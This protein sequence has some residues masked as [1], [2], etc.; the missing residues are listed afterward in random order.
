M[1]ILAILL[2]CAL[3]VTADDSEI[4][5]E[6]ATDYRL[7]NGTAP[8]HYDIKL[9][10]NGH[11]GNL[12]YRG[13]VKILVEVGE[14]TDQVILHAVNL[15]IRQCNLF[16][17]SGNDERVEL[18]GLNVQNILENEQ[19]MI[20]T[21]DLIEVGAHLLE[22]EF[23]ATVNSTYPEGIFLSSYEDEVGGKR[24]VLASQ[25]DP[26][27]ARRAY[28]CFDEPALKATFNLS[29]VH[30]KSHE[31]YS[32]MPA[33]G[34]EV[35]GGDYVET[36]FQQTPLMSIYLLVFCTTD[37]A[38]QT[39]GNQMAL[40]RKSMLE[41]ATESLQVSNEILDA[42]SK[43]TDLP[44]S[45]YVPKLTHLAVPFAE[46][47]HFS[48]MENWGMILYLEKFFVDP[49]SYYN[50]YGYGGNRLPAIEV[51]AHEIGHQWFGN[52]VTPQWWNHLWLK[53]GFA[54]LYQ[55]YIL[56]VIRP[57]ERWMDTFLVH[58][59]PRGLIDDEY[60]K[61]ISFECNNRENIKKQ[62][63]DYS[64]QKAAGAL[65][66]FRNVL[67][68]EKW[69]KA[70]QMYL[71]S[72]ALDNAT[73]ED[74]YSAIEAVSDESD[75]FPG[76]ISVE[77]IFNSWIL[78]EG[79][80]VLYVDRLEGGN[81]IILFQ[82][83]EQYC[84]TSGLENRMIPYNY[85]YESYPSFYETGPIE[86]L[87]DDLAQITTNA[88]YDEWIIFNKRRFGPYK[89]MYD[90]HNWRLIIRALQNNASCIHYLNRAQ[91]LDDAYDHNREGRLVVKIVF[92]LVTYLRNE[93]DLLVWSR[94]RRIVDFMRHHVRGKDNYKLF[95]IFQ[96][97]LI[98]RAY[99]SFEPQMKLFPFTESTH[100]WITNLACIGGI[101]RCLDA[102]RNAFSSAVQTNATVRP[103]EMHTVYCFG[104]R[105]A[106]EEEFSWLFLGVRI[107]PIDMA[108]WGRWYLYGLSSSTLG[109][110]GGDNEQSVITPLI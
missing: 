12:S 13:L 108:L 35:V 76:N 100:R 71:K 97:H 6:S 84:T 38:V 80:P 65:N 10:T 89:I 18:K 99:E 61:A 48:A 26:I 93:T 81:K 14:P 46:R 53:E 43:Y 19:L 11:E 2:A 91:L 4:A 60:T 50:L 41:K 59:M 51:I 77:E 101:D 85:A 66:M 102:A 47:A 87:T 17:L 36:V 69:Q 75:F 27:G 52:L 16:R 72:R 31:A 29:I 28:P 90:L 23:N 68:D 8:K 44:Y 74:L 86:W 15:S 40:V 21:N 42:L 107:G 56:D 67:G 103:E 32:N 79:T 64:Y 34:R 105:N 106:T 58:E 33:I 104:L 9:W 55:N 5:E 24:F 110:G 7:P 39:V 70:V 25:F 3:L 92:D 54:T 96:T 73:P 88:S 109:G 30:H 95:K 94:G 98:A 62:Y 49:P 45:D 22:I 20:S 63:N 83:R 57:N 82:E 78:E 37:L 1:S